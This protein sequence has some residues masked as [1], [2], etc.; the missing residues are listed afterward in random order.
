MAESL[1]FEVC[2]FPVFFRRR[3]FKPL[4]YIIKAWQTVKIF[5]I[6]KPDEI[7]VQ[8]PPVPLLNVALFYRRLRRDR[9]RIVADCHNSMLRPPWS[10][11]PGATAAL[12]G[13]DLVL[14]HNEAM[15]GVAVAMGVRRE[16][17]QVLEDAPVTFQAGVDKVS[18]NASPRVLFPASYS[19]DEPIDELLQ[20]ARIANEITFVLTGNAVRARGRFDLSR[21]PPN[22][23]LTGYLPVAEF[24]RLLLSADAVLALTRHEGIQLSVCSEAVGA[25]KP[26]IL[27]D[28]AI[29]RSLFGDVAVMVDS[30][31]PQALAQG[32]RE[33]IAGIE[34]LTRKTLEFRAQRWKSW[35]DGQAK[36]V[37]GRLDSNRS[38]TA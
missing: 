13:C 14:V 38:H 24:D 17:I 9:V 23:R 35:A 28:T 29:L 15:V 25:G 7:W 34:E 18:V 6:K 27:S 22:V 10:R 36:A 8:M 5:L 26:M 32:C 30:T 16:L 31:S 12:N 11:W 1:G 4:E 33:A 3:L 20:A 2:F 19:E 21:L 37:L